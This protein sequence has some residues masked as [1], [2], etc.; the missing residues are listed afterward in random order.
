[1]VYFVVVVGCGVVLMLRLRLPL[2]CVV[3]D[4]VVVNLHVQVTL[5]WC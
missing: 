4:N 5:M 3:D 1:M 2:M